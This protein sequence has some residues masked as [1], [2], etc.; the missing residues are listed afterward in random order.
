MYRTQDKRL[1]AQ[2]LA[3]IIR[4][5]SENLQVFRLS[6]DISQVDVVLSE[7]ANQRIQLQELAFSNRDRIPEAT[8]KALF[9]NCVS[10]LKVLNVY[11]P[12]TTMRYIAQ[13]IKIQEL[14]LSGVHPQR[15][16]ELMEVL[17]K[18]GDTLHVLRVAF[19]TGKTGAPVRP[20]N[21]S[22]VRFSE[23]AMETFAPFI[24]SRLSESFPVLHTLDVGGDR[25]RRIF[26]Y[27]YADQSRASEHALVQELHKKVTILRERNCMCPSQHQ[28]RHLILR[29]TFDSSMPIMDKCLNEYSALVVP[30][31]NLELQC[32]GA[33]VVFPAGN[34]VPYFKALQINLLDIQDFPEHSK[35]DFT[36]MEALD[37]GS[38]VFIKMY[39][40]HESLRLRMMDFVWESTDTLRELYVDSKVDSSSVMESICTYVGD[41]LEIAS[42]VESLTFKSSLVDFA[43]RGNAQF[44]RL[45]SFMEHI[46][47]LHLKANQ[48][49]ANDCQ[50]AF[51]KNFPMFLNAISRA[52]PDLE[53]F[54]L[55][56]AIPIRQTSLTS[57][58][59]YSLAWKSLEMCRKAVSDFEEALPNCDISSVRS[60]LNV[61]QHDLESFLESPLAIFLG[62]RTAKIRRQEA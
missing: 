55:E 16:F 34:D 53:C 25:A 5:A 40:A 61:W 23:C 49:H 31:V 6:N 15:V 19:L 1:T 39:S 9:E 13:A 56:L 18:V 45:L 24:C 3:A 51:G 4:L 46:K 28:L 21:S 41:I 62:Q 50:L 48:L 57:P 36:R 52:C 26:H 27:F 10:E 12:G 20:I 11:Q 8:E 60:Q 32:R 30:E 14:D 58:D 7:L 47:V 37:I 33:T 59:V 22:Y 42:Y 43:D 38:K 17:P 44:Q 29:D 2:N 54:D 35:Y